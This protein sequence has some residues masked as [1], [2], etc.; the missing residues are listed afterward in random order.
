M[1]SNQASHSFHGKKEAQWQL[2]RWKP[3]ELVDSR[4]HIAK[5]YASKPW[6][7]IFYKGLLLPSDRKDLVGR[8]LDVG[9]GT[10]FFTR[11]I[12][13]QVVQLKRPATVVG[14]DLN[15][16]LLEVAKKQSFG[17]KTEIEYVQASAY[18]LP[19]RSSFFDLVTCRTVLMHLSSPV[20]ALREM[21]RMARLGGRVACEEPD[22]GM[23]GYSDPSDPEFVEEDQRVK[24]A[25]IL[26]RS[27]IYGQ[28][29]A[30]G[31]RLPELLH[32]A[33]LGEIILDGMF[34]SIRVPCDPRIK[35]ASLERDFSDQLKHLSDK[36]DLDEYKKILSAGGLTSKEIDHYLRVW[37]KR[38][39]KRIKSLRQSSK[40]KEKDV[41]FY[42]IPFF[43]A[44]G[45]K[46][47]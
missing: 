32:N 1:Q 42:A 33:R 27:R 40:A 39:K 3:K 38:T 2:K 18:H 37:R 13:N 34:H 14:A 23:T 30:I 15:R 29:P 25:E 11:F 22:W 47:Q 36:S 41:S 8:I 19:F 20:G 9:C 45:T 6:L 12:A 16:S 44:I 26:G 4:K 10:G 43:L 31:R 24:A 21:R 5:E 28:N 35:S 7:L 17:G 46:L